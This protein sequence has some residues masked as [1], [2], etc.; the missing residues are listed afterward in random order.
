MKTQSFGALRLGLW[1]QL[2]ISS[3][4]AAAPPLPAMAADLTRTSVSG[5]SSGG[6]MAAQ[7]ATAYSA[8]FMGVGV[9]AAGPYYCAGTY[10]QLSFVQNAVTTCM[11]PVVAAAGADA[12]V[13]WR[14]AQHFASEGRIDP[15][16]NLARQRVYVFSGARDSTVR[17]VVVD[18]VARYYRLAGA[19]EGQILY[20]KNVDAGH[21]ILTDAAEDQLCDTTAAPYVNNCGFMQS[22]RLLAHLYAPGSEAPSAA[23]PA[24]EIIRF[25]QREF[26][27]GR[28][29]SMDEDG[30]AYVPRYCRE[31]ACVVHVALHGCRQ[32]A[33]VV[34]DRFYGH[35][36][37][38]AFADSNR[39]IVLYPQAAASAG[40]PANPLGCWDFW[41]YSD[42]SPGRPAFYAREAPQMA[43]IVAMVR[44]LGQPRADQDPP[45]GAQAQ[46]RVPLQP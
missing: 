17:T 27:H 15:V 28:R 13:S 18:Q 8:T 29:S 3:A 4:Y 12:A 11:T 24:G 14:N 39:M 9:I 34:G 10:P 23:A 44:R 35:T 16:T 40:I 41:G 32:G 26:V 19:A 42:E 36:G 37:Y 25:D 30:Y 6:F 5:I 7:L 33:R 2:S 20:Q 1:L 31:H 21:A 45:A 46:T 43:A 38:N 22:Q